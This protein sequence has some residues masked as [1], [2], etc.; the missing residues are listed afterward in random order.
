MSLVPS[1]GSSANVRWVAAS[2]SAGTERKPR[3]LTFKACSPCQVLNI[4]GSGDGGASG[5]DPPPVS[6]N[7]IILLVFYC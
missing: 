4:G 7:E 2:R 5:G 6:L 3:F 1:P